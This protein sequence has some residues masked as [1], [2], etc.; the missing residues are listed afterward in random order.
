MYYKK[1][2]GHDGE[3]EACNYLSKMGYEII[4]RNFS[5]KTGEIDIIALDLETREIVFIEVKSRQ[6]IRYGY[7][8]EAVDKKKREH[9]R[10]TA[11]YYAYINNI[12]NHKF[13]FDVIEVYNLPKKRL[14]IHHIIQAIDFD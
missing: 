13:R 6:Q 8:I 11:E 9:I 14:K 7:P 1:E 2:F 10:K 12:E 5:C 4:N 3:D